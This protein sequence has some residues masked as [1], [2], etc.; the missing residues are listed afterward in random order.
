[1]R[2]HKGQWKYVSILFHGYIT[3]RMRG[4]YVKLDVILLRNLLTLLQ[5]EFVSWQESTRLEHADPDLRHVRQPNKPNQ[6]YFSLLA[7]ERGARRWF[8]SQGPFV[9]SVAQTN[10][11]CSSGVIGCR[12]I[13]IPP[14][15]SRGCVIWL[16]PFFLRNQ[17]KTWWYCWAACAV[18]LES[19]RLE[20]VQPRRKQSS[21]KKS[22]R[23]G[24]GWC[25][26]CS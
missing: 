4:S 2:T 8:L 23:T 1:M 24:G 19:V 18:R 17:Y 21:G 10:G 22:D 6:T 13:C 20:S 3:W 12:G 5:I 14:L 11:G 9:R 26:G 15:T 16:R 7:P 25:T